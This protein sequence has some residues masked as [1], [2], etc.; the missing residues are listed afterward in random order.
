MKPIKDLNLGF[1]D[2]ENYLK[3]SNR[4]FYE[5]I[6]IKNNNLDKLL[7]ETTYFLIGEK[8]T[9]KTGYAVYLANKE[10]NGFS[11]VIK[12]MQNTDYDKFYNLKKEKHLQLSDYNDIW[13]VILLL[14]MAMSINES[15]IDKF[16]SYKNKKIIEL[17]KAIDCYYSNAF[18]PEI[19]YVL[20]MVKESNVAA[21][22]LGELL[23]INGSLSKKVE[24]QIINFQT[25]LSTLEKLF[26]E[27]I[28]D[29]KLQKNKI[30]FVDGI[31][32]RPDTIEYNE[33]IEIVRG[34]SNAILELNSDFFSNIKDSKGRMKIVLLLRPDIFNSLKFH[35]PTNKLQD[36]SVYLSWL[37]GYENYRNSQIFFLVDKL[38]SSQQMEK[39]EIGKTW[40]YYN[41]WVQKSTNPTKRDEDD[42]FISILRDTYYRPRDLIMACKIMQEHHNEYHNKD[43]DADHF[44]SEN[45]LSNLS[46][47]KYSD[48]ILGTIK[49][50]LLFYYTTSDYNE[51]LAFFTYL[52]RKSDFSYDEYL[53]AFENYEKYLI[54][55][56]KSIPRF[57][58]SAEEFLQFLYENNILSYYEYNENEK[59]LFSWCYRERKI[60]NIEPR[61]KLHINYR[62]HYGLLKALGLQR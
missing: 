24:K 61:V 25:S 51:F 13:K 17:K 28:R 18:S 47:N 50:Q 37:T 4:E 19:T 60:S 6:F 5:N 39:H 8:G 9:G 62:I 35:N 43:K 55:K 38:F 58:D 2:A 57:V 10:Y 21:Q 32:I 59:I 22:V 46:Q 42:A 27:T 14:L 40:D 49:D 56:S 23:T 41:S 1:L 48:Y 29:L 15:D 36:N 54:E 34:L 45:F 30:L 7:L 31:D 52:N 53:A 12:F 33:Y 16:A 20:N 44:K 3:K 11:S 26:K